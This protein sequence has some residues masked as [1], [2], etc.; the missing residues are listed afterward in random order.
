[1]TIWLFIGAAVFG[2]LAFDAWRM[3]RQSR[4]LPYELEAEVRGESVEGV[5]L[6]EQQVRQSWHRRFG[7]GKASDI[8]WFWLLLTACCSVA[9]LLQ[10]LG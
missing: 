6:V 5:S 10:V 9:L 1:M 2:L 7:L 3:G 4:E 8:V